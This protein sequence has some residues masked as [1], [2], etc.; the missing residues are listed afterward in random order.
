[1]VDKISLT[2]EEKY[3]KLDN[4]DKDNWCHLSGEIPHCIGNLEKLE[5]LQ[6]SCLDITGDI[7]EEMW[8]PNLAELDLNGCRGL[9]GTLDGMEKCRE[10]WWCDINKVKIRGGFPDGVF[11]KNGFQHISHFSFQGCNIRDTISCRTL[12]D[13][14]FESKYESGVWLLFWE[15]VVLTDIELWPLIKD[16][17]VSGEFPLIE[18][19]PEGYNNKYYI[20]LGHEYL[21]PP[22][23]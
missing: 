3:N 19:C 20:P 18:Y 13:T 1:M 21:L 8:L 4:A 23:D 2:D 22:L 15:G 6:L 7:P 9:G 11:G 12:A 14:H 16:Y 10:L 17:G 5:V